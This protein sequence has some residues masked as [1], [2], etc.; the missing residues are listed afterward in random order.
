MR[1][2]K[3]ICTLGPSTDK[4]GV[5]EELAQAGMNIARMNFSH[6]TYEDHKRRIDKIA[7]IRK[8]YNKHIAVLL[9]TKGPEIRTENFENGRVSLKKGDSFILYC[10]DMV[11]NENGVSITYRDLYREVD[12]GS[13]ILIDD[14]LI[15][16]EVDFVEDKD[17]HCTLKND[18]VIANHKG[19]N[20]P[21][22]HI[23]MEYISAKDREDILFGIEND[24]DFI[25][26]SFV[27]SASDVKA[28]RKLLAENGGENIN[29]IAKIEN[30]EGVDNIDEIIEVSDG[31]MI[32]RGDMGVE[33]PEE[34]VPVVQKMITKKG[35]EAG[36]KVIT[37]TQM[38][39]SMI[40]NKRPTRAE[41]TDVANAI[42]DG[43]SA[44]MLS[45]ETAAGSFPVESLKTMVKIAERTE[46][47]I[48]YKARFFN[49]EKKKSA[50]ITDAICHAT[51]TTAY[52]LGASAIVTVTK[53]GNSARMVS[54]YRPD[55]NIIAGST[56][57]K[58]CRQLSLSWGITPI[59][60]K[61][62]QDVFSLFEHA[63]EISKSEG[64]LEK[65]QLVVIT[66]GVPIGI[67][68]TT[69]MLKVH[70]VD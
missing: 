58:I 36:K 42:Y 10:R 57:E 1:K 69:N 50:S 67:S 3:I 70:I 14:G 5:L 2:T 28:I 22:L 11:G 55:C 39:E 49:K 33:L 27:R 34:E 59:L 56:D 63:V 23:N 35:Y 9:D 64:L 12:K 61:E 8:K 30:R 15:E 44:I 41:A 25:A 4:E 47:D 43:T 65:G 40:N 18:G 52:D 53:S 48:N 29:I 37:A 66:S 20:I 51:C 54:S 60:L 68:G 17:I 26:A 31:I 16:L 38:L 19:V 13:I 6:S 62:K 24:V 45:G 46:R 32:A 21:G 7:E